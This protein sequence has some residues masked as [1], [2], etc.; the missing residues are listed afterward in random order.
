MTDWT[1]NRARET[2]RILR[3]GAGYFD[4]NAHGHVVARPH[5]EQCN[6]ID[7]YALINELK[8]E[9]GEAALSLPLLLR[10]TDILSDRVVDL[11]AA[12]KKSMAAVDYHAPYCSVYPIKVNQQHSVIEELL[13]NELLSVG[14]EA[15]S[16]PELMI[17]LAM[18]RNRDALVICNG[19]KDS[20]YIRLSLIGIKLGM[21]VY[22]VIEKISELEIVL[23]E[24][25]ALDIEPLIGLRIRLSS[26]GK[27]NWQNS[28]GVKSKFGL[29]SM[30]VL[31]MVER[32]KAEGKLDCL[33][34]MHVHLGS[35]IANIKDIQR[36]MQ[37]VGCC[38]AELKR[39]GA[40][41]S[42]VDVGGGLGVDYE[43]TGSRNFCSMNYTWQDYANTIVQAM[44]EVCIAHNLAQPEL[45]T[46]SGRAMTAHHAV[47]VT[48]V[49]D[50]ESVSSHKTLL[51][52]N[53]IENYAEHEVIRSMRSYLEIVQE[54][55]NESVSLLEI[56][57]DAV[58]GLE[59]AHELFTQGVLD[60]HQRALVEQL[61]YVVCK[62][63]YPQL[64]PSIRSH[65]DLLD[66]LHEKLAD[67]YFCNFSVFQSVPDVWAIDQIFPIMPI[68]RLDTAP[69]Q[70]GVIVDVT[71]DSDGRVD[72]YVDH[73]GIETTLPL[74]SV[75]D[76][77]E[78][79]L[80]MFLVGAYQE[81]L[82]D[83]HNLFGDTNAVNIRR[84]D[85]G[86]YRWDSIH[87]GDTVDSVLR[88]VNFSAPDLMKI[89]N[90]KI[91]ASTLT[92]NEKKL[93]LHELE[94]GL[95]GYTYLED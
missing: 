57:H 90:N 39:L 62:K 59:Q 46:E 6:E 91:D 69:M 54:N 75:K 50:V 61:Y 5:T 43:G 22:I 23:R 80:G 52:G 48:N 40:N 9:V 73:A 93:F 36:G 65:R 38:Y 41:I 14:L 37:E 92:V 63:I 29:S 18:S 34:L 74:H 88:H 35:Q 27:G 15:G 51:S 28:G 53:A 68:H 11:H 49:I 82:G 67:K 13:T 94:V 10:F 71:C 26:I 72:H 47:L 12:F 83:I 25:A 87:H 21:R 32:L 77:D 64:H 84:G 55:S 44:S 1:I 3:W 2:Y 45:I 30:Q 7:L 86:E 33:Q 42:C 19:Y 58:H 56:Y 66:E 16:K 89:F 95:S 8:N 76:G 85:D 81:I 70:R 60:L 24:S 17:V 79:L 20:E 4:V 78:Y 31:E